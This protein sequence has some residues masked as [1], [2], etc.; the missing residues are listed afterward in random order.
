MGRTKE[1][2]NPLAY[3]MSEKYNV[4]TYLGWYFW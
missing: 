1:L 3:M 2:R 4:I